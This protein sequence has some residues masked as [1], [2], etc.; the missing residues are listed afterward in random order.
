[1]GRSL[2]DLLAS[3]A[4]RRPSHVAVEDLP[5]G[6]ATYADLDALSGRVRNR[7]RAFG[8]ARGDR[9]GVYLRKSIDAYA[10]ILGAMKAGAAY[11]PVDA[12]LPPARAAYITSHCGVAALVVDRGLVPAWRVSAAGMGKL[13][14]QLELES[15]G[16]GRGLAAALDRADAVSPAQAVETE[17]LDGR[18]LAYILYTSGS[19]GAPKGVML[20]H[21]CALSHV[22]WCVETL[23]PNES[24]RFSSHAPFHFDLSITDLYVPLRLGAT[25]VL[26][27]SERG[28]D[29][30][31]LAALIAER[32]LT[33]W[34]STPS[35][36][37]A[38]SEFGKMERH[39]YS[40]LRSVYFAGEVFPVKHL[41]A[42]KSRLPRARFYNLYGP[43]E[44]NVCAWQ[45]IPSVVG[46]DRTEP[47]PI[48]RIC[49]HFRGRVVD[50]DG[51]DVP[52][53]T[54]GELVVH[55][56]G[57]LTGY[58]NDPTRTSAAFVVDA[59]GLLWYRTGD[60]VVRGGD[61]HDF[62][63]RRDRMV[64]RRGYRIELGDIE[65]ALHHHLGIAEAAAIARVDAEGEVGIIAFV[66]MAPGQRRSQI[67]VRRFCAETLPGYMIP[68][69]FEFV[70]ELPKTSTDKIDYQRLNQAG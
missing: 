18:D 47:Y 49:A 32:R 30:A 59:A 64:K 7:L 23:G 52:D 50:D 3:S 4:G 63:G 46:D 48:G 70:D 29:P 67:D 66:A 65:A 11:V 55:G 35:V 34:Y 28:K 22:N 16:G 44:T 58:W 24:D 38:L 17:G 43:T 45:P 5:D 33:V 15:T 42:V 69:R 27:D 9:V 36:L 2:L 6:Q 1:M 68:D 60:I 31:G 57:M 51:A 13:P 14:P 10:A 20:T 19:T 26:I 62:V 41:R 25:V 56:S 54:K 39:E 12:D 61:V 21:E 40:S 8:V 37:K 53:G